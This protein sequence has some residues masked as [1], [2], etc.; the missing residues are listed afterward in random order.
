MP[1]LS[2]RRTPLSLAVAV[3]V[4][5]IA[6]AFFSLMGCS[7]AQRSSRGCTGPE[8]LE[9]STWLLHVPELQDTPDHSVT[10]HAG[11]RM[12]T[13]H[14]RDTTPDNDEWERSDRGLRFW[15]NNRYA[16]YDGERT[17]AC[18]ITGEG[19]NTTGKQWTFRL[20]WPVDEAAGE[21]SDGESDESDQADEPEAPRKRTRA[22]F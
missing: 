7:G 10:F 14:P 1:Q 22:G 12:G 5:V 18:V 20:T 2:S 13:T 3:A 21:R 9:G 6:A 17:G 15:Y 16:W 8:D 19:G 11:G 4:V